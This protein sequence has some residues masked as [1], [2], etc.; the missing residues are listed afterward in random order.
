[1]S[2]RPEAR[3]LRVRVASDWKAVCSLRD[4]W[5]LATSANPALGPFQSFTWADCWWHAIGGPDATVEPW[6]ATVRHRDGACAG[7]LPMMTRSA[8]DETALEA[9]TAPW[10]D[11]H[12]VVSTPGAAGLVLEAVRDQLAKEAWTGPLT[13]QEVSGSS[14]V[15][16]AVGAGASP[17]WRW[18]PTGFCASILLQGPWARE[19]P[20]ARAEYAR[21]HRRLEAGRLRIV[22][23]TGE[24]LPAALPSFV[25]MHRRQWSHRPGLVAGFDQPGVLELYE[26]L[27]HRPAPDIHPILSELRWGTRPVAFYFGFLSGGS[28]LGY[29]TTFE[30]DVSKLSPGHVLLTLLC[31]DLQGRGLWAF[32]LMRGEYGYKQLYA[33][34]LVPQGRAEPAS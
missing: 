29:R 15:A 17:A 34:Y 8:G 9:F 4:E 33:S 18:E 20:F 10:A 1:M 25:E 12:D 19:V 2:R 22:H 11:Y 7:I 5:C 6:I 14:E 13:L 28:Y 27:V 30:V 31:R 26:R 16:K 32:D 21:K 24:A 23:H 3:R